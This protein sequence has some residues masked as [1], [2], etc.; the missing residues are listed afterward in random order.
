MQPSSNI[1][2]GFDNAS[3][4]LC[5]F[6]LLASLRELMGVLVRVDLGFG[7]LFVIACGV[8]SAAVF[9]FGTIF[10]GILLGVEQKA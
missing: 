7:V 8:P 10:K 1:E 2:I 6:S 4:T 5:R 9:P 3:G